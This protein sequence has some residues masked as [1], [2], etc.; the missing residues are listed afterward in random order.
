MRAQRRRNPTSVK[1]AGARLLPTCPGASMT[2]ASM[3]QRGGVQPRYLFRDND[4]MYG[5]GIRA[6]LE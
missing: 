4:G 3:D 6:F 1:S 5:N 2:W